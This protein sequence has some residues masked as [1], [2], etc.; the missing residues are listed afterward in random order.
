MGQWQ[1]WYNFQVKHRPNLW[2]THIESVQ[3]LNWCLLQVSK[4]VIIIILMKA[5]GVEVLQALNYS[6]RQKHSHSETDYDN[7]NG[8]ESQSQT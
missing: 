7:H 6:N 5:L 4:Q 8:T 1:N 3:I 2:V